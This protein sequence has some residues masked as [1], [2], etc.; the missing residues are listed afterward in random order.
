ML[1]RSSLGIPLNEP[2]PWLVLVIDQ[3]R[4]YDWMLRGGNPSESLRLGLSLLNVMM[5]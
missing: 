3:N 4:E 1:T 5:A 2:L